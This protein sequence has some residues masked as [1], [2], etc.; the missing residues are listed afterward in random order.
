MEPRAD[1]GEDFGFSGLT[2]YVQS[3]FVPR[4]A[5]GILSFV[6]SL[7][8]VEGRAYALEVVEDIRRLTESLLSDDAL[9]IVW[10]AATEAR[11]DPSGGNLTIRAWLQR[12]AD[13]CI[14]F[15]RREDPAFVPSGPGPVRHPELMDTV[16]VEIRQVGAALNEKAVASV[17][18]PPLAALVPTLEAAVAELGPDLG[19][20]L[21]LRAMKVYFVPIGP[22]RLERFERIGSQ[23][24]YHEWVVEDGSLNI[25]SDLEN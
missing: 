20:R 25:W 8:D 1:F 24:G 23:L 9:S 14:G 12:I 11:F 21:F 2:K 6:E 4:E 10:L 19:F 18:P 3:R 16:L 13:T 7:L 15:V 22:A 17:Y 5:A